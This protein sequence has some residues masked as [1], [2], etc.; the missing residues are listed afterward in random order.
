[1]VGKNEEYVPRMDAKKDDANWDMV[2]DAYPDYASFRVP[3]HDP[4]A[5]RLAAEH[6]AGL[7]QRLLALT[8][9]SAGLDKHA[10]I[11][12]CYDAVRMANAR[13]KNR[14]P[15]MKTSDYVYGERDEN[16][17]VVN[18]RPREKS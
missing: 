6:M 8:H 4:L 16:W 2:K 1:M 12:K 10:T 14:P 11:S 15:R 9:R 17:R 3:L 13:V 7:A 5:I 18:I